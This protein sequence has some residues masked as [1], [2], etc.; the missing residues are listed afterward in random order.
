MLLLDEPVAG[1]DPAASREFYQIIAQLNEK[2]GVTILMISHDMEAA[3]R[4]A[5]H[6]LYLGEKV[7]FGTRDAFAQSNSGRRY[8]EQG[9]GGRAWHC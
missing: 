1:L 6:I 9:E 8:L 2:D 5:S 4:Y 7:F 3:L